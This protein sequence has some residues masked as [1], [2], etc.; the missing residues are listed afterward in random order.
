MFLGI[1]RMICLLL[2]DIKDINVWVQT[3]FKTKMHFLLI[4]RNFLT[5]WINCSLQNNNNN[6]G[7]GGHNKL[8][9]FFF[10]WVNGG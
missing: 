1:V 4:V 5:N 3:H 6:N 8:L 9:N 7:K 2:E 10:F